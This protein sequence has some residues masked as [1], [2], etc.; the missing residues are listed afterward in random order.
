MKYFIIMFVTILV[1]AFCVCQA[2]GGYKRKTG[3]QM[4][5]FIFLWYLWIPLIFV[6]K[7][8]WFLLL[9]FCELAQITPK[10]LGIE[11]HVD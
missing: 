5:W 10:E 11:N 6:Y 2:N 7:I 9:I 1:C 4:F 3:R 8:I